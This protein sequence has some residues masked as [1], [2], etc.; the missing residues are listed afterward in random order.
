MTV[1]DLRK[2]DDYFAKLA[3]GGLCVAFSGGVDSTVLLK[4]AT[5]TGRDVHAVT[6]VSPLH[7]PTERTEAKRLAEAMGAV[8]H[9]LRADLPEAVRANTRERCYLCKR[10]LFF[11]IQQ[12]AR[13]QGLKWVLDGTNRD[14]LDA[15]RPGLR[16]LRELGVLSPLA[17]LGMTKGAVRALAAELGL[18]VADKPSAPCLATRF[19]YDTPI[20]LAL[21]PAVDA[22]EQ[23]LR[24][25]GL[26]QVRARVIGGVARVEALPEQF[27][28][29]LA[30]REAL[31][32]RC[33][34]LGFVSASL[35]LRG[36]RS[37]SMDELYQWEQDKE[38]R[39]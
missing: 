11:N 18:A 30:Q 29:L 35:D 22:L 26:S 3:D 13:S 23:F 4:A 1:S 7:S 6:L 24:E 5:M 36:F 16:A 10:D 37:G 39:N 25:L 14:D 2:L 9:V 15:Y 28:T 27:A 8:H 21:L 17:E 19:P 34:E 12:Y 32:A 38:A 33:R 20:D 31:L